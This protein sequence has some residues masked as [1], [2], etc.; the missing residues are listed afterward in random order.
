LEVFYSSKYKKDLKN[1]RK[2]SDFKEEELD[3]VV[4]ALVRKQPLNKKYK[5]HPLAG[6]WKGYRDCH[7]QNDVVLFYKIEDGVLH[8]ARLH[9]HANFL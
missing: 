4:N 9:A 8:L 2:R 5:D 6:E 3:K 7:V 1:M